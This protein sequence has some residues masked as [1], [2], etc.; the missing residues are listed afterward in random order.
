M[1]A[2]QMQDRDKMTWKKYSGLV[3]WTNFAASKGSLKAIVEEN[4]TVN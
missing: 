3:A 4:L 1:Q 2:R